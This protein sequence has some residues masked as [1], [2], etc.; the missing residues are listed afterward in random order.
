MK[1]LL[2]YPWVLAGPTVATRQWLD[3][4]FHARGL[5][6][7]TVQIETNLIL[8]LPPLIEQNHLLSFVSRRHLTRGSP[9]KEVAVR[10]TTMR[11]EFAVT[12][13]SDSY[14]SPAARRCVE[15]LRTRGPALFE[16]T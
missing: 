13:R 14:L 16:E 7:P 3:H 6:G 12:F 1:D 15:M 11:R 5:P 4:A 10:E 2:E 9:L 8:L